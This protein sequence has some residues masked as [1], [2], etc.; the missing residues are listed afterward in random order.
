MGQGLSTGP[1][2]EEVLAAIT[3]FTVFIMYVSL[4][5]ATTVCLGIATGHGHG[6]KGILQGRVKKESRSR[7]TGEGQS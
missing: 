1:G 4:A 7:P 3:S 6:L 5:V 2:V